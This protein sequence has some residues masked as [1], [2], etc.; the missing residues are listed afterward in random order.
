[1][2]E[3]LR[4]SLENVVVASASDKPVDVKSAVEIILAQKV[5]DRLEAV[6]E[7]VAFNMFDGGLKPDGTPS[8]ESEEEVEDDSADLDSDD[9]DDLDLDDLDLDDIDLED[10]SDLEG[11]DE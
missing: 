9:L 10:A 6:K 4:E 3:E 8:E 2:E 7:N 5:L 1:M 11:S